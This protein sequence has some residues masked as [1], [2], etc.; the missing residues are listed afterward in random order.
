M[1]TTS[2]WCYF[3][4]T[5]K[6]PTQKTHKTIADNAT[7]SIFYT[8]YAK[9]PTLILFSI[10]GISLKFSPCIS[11]HPDVMWPIYYLLTI[12]F[13]RDPLTLGAHSA[14]TEGLVSHKWL[15]SGLEFI[16]FCLLVF[17]FEFL[18]RDLP[19]SISV[20][21]GEHILHDH[22]SIKSRSKFPFSRCHL[23]MNV[24]WELERRGQYRPWD[25]VA[26][27]KAGAWT[28]RSWD[29]GVGIW[30]WASKTDKIFWAIWSR[31]FPSSTHAQSLL[32]CP[33]L[34]PHGP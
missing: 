29:N 22:L 8:T 5:T 19:V 14:T 25:R 15:V 16:V 6:P 13:L 12:S 34:R 28:G 18:S 33:T 11:A 4:L 31:F 24:L 21:V 10:T 27:H 32:L 7:F 17:E 3:L 1:I 9:A 20:L 30:V 26:R 23:G 2:I